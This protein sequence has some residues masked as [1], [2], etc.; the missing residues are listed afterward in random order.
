MS[1]IVAHPAWV[2]C[3]SF[4]GFLCT[5]H[6]GEHAHDCDCPAIEEWACDPYSAGGVDIEVSGCDG[7]G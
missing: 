1:V 5:I 2:R 6:T 3:E 4:D 7:G